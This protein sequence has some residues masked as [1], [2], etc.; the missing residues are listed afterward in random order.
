MH[1]DKRRIALGKIAVNVG[2]AMGYLG[3]NLT[4]SELKKVYTFPTNEVFDPAKLFGRKEINNTK[5]DE[6][7]YIKR[8]CHFR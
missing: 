2:D 6:P 8:R 1:L 3:R 7:V 4:G 5:K